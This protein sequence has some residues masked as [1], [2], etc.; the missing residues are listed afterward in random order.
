MPIARG[1]S[2]ILTPRGL[3][4]I[5]TGFGLGAVGG[6][7]GG[8]FGITVGTVNVLGA[9]GT[10]S[11]TTP[12]GSVGDLLVACV[13]NENNNGQTASSGWT[14]P[15]YAANSYGNISL[16][17]YYRVADGSG[18]DTLTVTFSGTPAVGSQGVVLR[19]S[20]HD[21]TTPFDTSAATPNNSVNPVQVPSVTTSE[22]GALVLVFLGSAASDLD[23]GPSG[24]YTLEVQSEPSANT[25]LGWSR[26]VG[27]AGSYGGENVTLT[28]GIFG[29]IAAIAI[30]PA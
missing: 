4:S 1:L 17:V 11:P 19:I 13:I 25:L 15:V 7:G 29:V 6:G 21:G 26:E 5:G 16:G 22:S 10:N 8:G 2:D 24:G 23:T 9:V 18:D 27:A 12:S 20:G 14:R 3:H 28:G 30:N